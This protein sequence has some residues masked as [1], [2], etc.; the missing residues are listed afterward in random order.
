MPFHFI[1]VNG[2]CPFLFQTAGALQV[3][4]L[5]MDLFPEV[6]GK[7]RKELD[8]VIGADKL[9]SISDQIQLPYIRSLVL[10]VLRWPIMPVGC[11]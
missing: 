11:S 8:S 9:P 2:T 1:K 10:E 3:S 7:A 5:A 6:P 4:V